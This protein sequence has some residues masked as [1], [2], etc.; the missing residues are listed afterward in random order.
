MPALIA[1]APV[2]AIPRVEL[3]RIDFTVLGVAALLALLS[4]LA[5]GLLPAIRAARRSQALVSSTRTVTL[6]SE[7]LHAAFVVVEIAL[8]VI[9]LTGAG[10][11]LKSFLRLRAVD[12]GFN[13]TN[14]VTATIDLPETSYRTTADAERFHHDA[15]AAIAALPDVESAGVVNWLPFGMMAMRGDFALEG[16][17][18]PPR[19][20]LVIKPAVSA[21]YFRAMGIRLIDGRAFTER[22]DDR[23]QPVAIVTASV[24]RELWPGERAIG[25]RL[26]L[27]TPPR[28]AG[29]WLTVVGVV[30]DIRQGGLTED[31]SRAIYQPYQ[32]VQSSFFVS[33]MTFVVR[34]AADPTRLL[35]SLRDAFRRIDP[36]MPV[37]TLVPMS[38]LVS[39][40]MAS[41]AFQARLLS[42]FAVAALA[43]TIVGIY[44]V[45]AYAVTRRTR[46]FGIRL[47]L[48]S[49]SQD[50]VRLVVI[51]AAVLALVGVAIGVAGALA[52]TRVLGQL[53]FEVTPTDPPTFIT[54]VI[55]LA[56]AALTAAAI[57]AWRAAHVDPVVALRAE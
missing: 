33:H 8:A 1:L 57:P 35:P 31:R 19:G 24:A 56:A 20:Y 44:G 25:Q 48:G 43:L 12:T 30:D 14:V 16:G 45:M 37:P 28:S 22:D 47:A 38:Q 42:I 7:R 5:F 26:S 36:D 51:K 11:M 54:V 55:L 41:P 40:Q 50:V 3:I 21:D 10:L 34:T 15:L 13:A 29:D 23:A 32:Q 6:H 17:R 4:A 18:T 46:E 9:L 49:S 2:G 53:L 39:A 27:Q 52:L